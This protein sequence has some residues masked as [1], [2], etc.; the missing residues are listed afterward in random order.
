MTGVTEEF[1]ADAA[2][3]VQAAAPDTPPETIERLVRDYLDAAEPHDL[4]VFAAAD[5]AGAVLSVLQAPDDVVRVGNPSTETDGWESPH[6]VVEIATED[7]PF[8]VD[9]VSTAIVRRGYDIH[10]LFRP[11]LGTVSHLH[12]EIDRETDPDRLEQLRTEL[13]AVVGDVHSAVGDWSPMR[14]RVVALA[15][16]LRLSPPPTADAA[17]VAEA[18][19]YLDWLADDHFTLVAAVR[20]GLDGRTVPGSELGIGSFA[21]GQPDRHADGAS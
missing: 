8:I 2:A 3:R 9:S 6:T 11:L 18:V 19:T 13:A 1:L 7:L 21:S 12:V 15:D 16:A 20:A 5:V 10:L 14:A 17:D 4:A